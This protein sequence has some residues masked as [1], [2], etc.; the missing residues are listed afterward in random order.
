MCRN[1]IENKNITLTYILS[2]T[3]PARLFGDQFRLEHVLGNLLSN[4]IKISDF[5]SKIV[6]S[7]AYESRLH[8]HVTFSVRDYGCGMSTEDQKLLFQPFMQIRPGELQ[9]LGS[10]LGLSIC[11]MLITL[12]QGSIGCISQLR[13]EA[14]NPESGG[15]EFYFNIEYIE[16][17]S[18]SPEHSGH[19]SSTF[20]AVSSPSRPITAKRTPTKE[21]KLP[22]EVMKLDFTASVASMNLAISH[23]RKAHNTTQP[24]TTLVPD[25]AECEKENQSNYPVQVDDIADGRADQPLLPAESTAGISSFL[26]NKDSTTL[27][28]TSITTTTVVS[29]SVH[30]SPIITNTSAS[31]VLN[32]LVVDGKSDYALL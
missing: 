16:P 28:S 6:I 2:P 8:N 21:D 32:I 29:D 10:G 27:P 22:K 13:T 17:P 26:C 7:I 19:D 15:S 5:G 3:I 14:S 25:T 18:P 9:R 23:Q 20:H 24:T 4:A 11:K 31:K 30:L 1:L 12:H